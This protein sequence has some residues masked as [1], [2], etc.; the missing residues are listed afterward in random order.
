VQL[1]HQQRLDCVDAGDSG[2]RFLFTGDANGKERNEQGPGTPGHVELQLLN[3]EA[4]NPGTLKADVTKVPHHGS[5]TANTQQ[6]IN[7]VNPRFVVISASNIHHLPRTPWFTATWVLS[8][9]F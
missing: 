4:G 5:E 9:R 1:P 7:A 2:S 6:F 8:E 3:L